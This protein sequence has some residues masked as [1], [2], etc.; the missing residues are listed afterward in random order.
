ME[1][2]KFHTNE[3][4]ILIPEKINDTN[5]QPF[6]LSIGP[7]VTMALPI[8]LMALISTKIYGSNNKFMYMSLATG[9]SACLMGIIWAIIN[10]SYKKKLYR[11]KVMKSQDEFNRYLNAMDDYLRNC[12]ED[13]KRYLLSKYPSSN[14]LMN[15]C[16]N[17]NLYKRHNLDED[18]L[19]LRLNIGRTLFQ[20]KL[21]IKDSKE[22]MFP[23]D[24]RMRANELIEKYKYLEDV[25]L[26]INLRKTRFLGIIHDP[27]NINHYLNILNI[28]VQIIYNHSPDDLKMA[29]IFDENNKY[30]RQIY[31]SIKYYPHF[32]TSD[33]LHRFFAGNKHHAEEI[34]PQ[35]NNQLHSKKQH[36]VLLI[37]N[38][39]LLTEETIYQFINE[40]QSEKIS[41]IYIQS[42][43]N[44]PNNV[45]D[46]VNLS[47]EKGYEI[48]GF[49]KSDNLQRKLMLT[50]DNS[51]NNII[52][53]K[54]DF[55]RLFDAD[56]IENLNIFDRWE[57]ARIDKR[58]NVPIG[59]SYGKRKIY[60]DIHEKFHG[61][62]GLVAGTTGSGKSE[63]IQT[64]I[65]SLCV[66][67]SPE[68]INFFLIDYK[69]GGTGQYI[70]ELPHCAGVISNLSGESIGRAMKAIASENKRRQKLLLDAGVN[71][72]DAYQA[73][74][75]EGK[76]FM[77]MPHLLL[78]IDEFAE[79]KKEAYEFM[80]Q[81]ISLAA[82]GRSLG[83]HLLLST[84]KPAGVVDD[85]IW[86][87][88]NFKLC[89]RVQ[90]KQ[91]SMDMLHRSEAAY[92]TGPGQCYIQIGNDEY[93]EKFQTG[94]CGG[95]YIVDD[96]IQPMISLMDITGKQHLLK[97]SY[98]DEDTKIDKLEY[99]V[100]YVNQ[101]CTSNNIKAA[102]SLWMEELK[103]RYELCK[104]IQDDE[105]ESNFIL[106]MSDDP[107]N[108]EQKVFYYNV[109]EHGNLCIIGGPISGKSTLLKTLISQVKCED[110]YL[111]IDITQDDI[112]DFYGHRGFLGALRDINGITIFFYH[113]KKEYQMHK[114]KAKDNHLY[115]FID[116]YLDFKNALTEDENDFVLK[117]IN[118][119]IG[120][121]IYFIVTA[122]AISDVGQRL[123]DKFKTTLA[124]EMNDKFAYQDILRRY[125]LSVYPKNN[126]PGRCL[127]LVNDVV[128]EGQIAIYDKAED[129]VENCDNYLECVDI[130]NN[131]CFPEYK[132]VINRS[133]FMKEINNKNEKLLYIGYSLVSGYLRGIDKNGSFLIVG[134]DHDAKINLLDAVKMT[135]VSCFDL[136]YDNVYEY[137]DGPINID[138]V[139]KYKA[140][141]IY[142][143]ESFLEK[144]SFNDKEALQYLEGIILKINEGIILGIINDSKNLSL[145][146]YK[147]FRLMKDYNQ[148]ICL[149]G[150]T[151]NQ[152][153]LDFDDLG[154]SKSTQILKCDEGYMKIHNKNKSILVKVLLN[155]REDND[156]FD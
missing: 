38:V 83:I 21:S 8:I 59:I 147:L 106:G 17:E 39:E 128:L 132:K 61:P 71:H 139:D 145:S 107:L 16:E 86:S 112:F 88:S 99:M 78:V 23:S 140:F 138:K 30:Q 129:A 29:Y 10:Y 131:R 67:F 120:I 121:G 114:D 76:V 9:G 37:F 5:H 127:Y 31:E 46:Y 91:D 77:P 135:M 119:G 64:F 74:Y 25:P 42:S 82:V 92:L 49:D 90:D 104:L 51:F 154:F 136:S 156:D 50:N 57:K 130:T 84:Q 65:M 95:K 48:V 44:F 125:H 96:L 40:N 53:S 56:S 126:T 7:T 69:G 45:K 27:L 97:N 100:N 41:V 70:R 146:S 2:I 58:I 102:D 151:A 81:I 150:N 66:S 94:Y 22:E 55:L 4:S 75:H 141:I 108:Q 149:G 20:M 72:V 12:Q 33:Y 148:G 87:N 26:G 152:R 116:N 80:S 32:K 1:D 63:L 111:L 155:E 153:I 103:D 109:N 79:L 110:E 14:E 73:L 36:T 15:D 142:D 105:S 24:E 89:L 34:I 85:K 124:L 134:D 19:F 35:L 6:L 143:V 62:H 60:L 117:L 68:D 3:V 28:I 123:F 13:N 113:L 115:I 11:L 54:V 122:G 133:V 98:N 101:L 43:N 52:P 137:R 18:F 47:D 93:F 118:E 144:I